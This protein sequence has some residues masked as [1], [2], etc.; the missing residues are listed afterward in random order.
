M[1]FK[2]LIRFFNFIKC[3]FS[4]GHNYYMI[5][6]HKVGHVEKEYM[7]G[8]YINGIYV[9]NHDE[10]SK[11]HHCINY[12]TNYFLYENPIKLIDKDKFG[13]K[14]YLTAN[15]IKVNFGNNKKEVE[16]SHEKAVG[17]LK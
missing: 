2:R 6:D 7:N 15:R 8:E 11:C 13:I 14:F 10:C 16:E 4:K 3:I 1:I 12:R 17:W 9:L 5:I